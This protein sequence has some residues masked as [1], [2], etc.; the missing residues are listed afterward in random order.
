[1]FEKNDHRSVATWFVIVNKVTELVD[2]NATSLELSTKY[3][4]TECTKALAIVA[5]TLV[6]YIPAMHA[7]F[8]WDDDTHL[9]NNIVLQKDGLYRIWFTTE[10]VNYWPITWTSYWIEHQLWGLDPTGYHVDNVI[11]HA[12]AALLIWRILLRIRYVGAMH[13]LSVMVRIVSRIHRPCV[14]TTDSLVHTK[15]VT[16]FGHCRQTNM[17]YTKGQAFQSMREPSPRR[18]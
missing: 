6:I 7:G 9:L 18:L 8:V 5:T 17:V 16:S 12:F 11:L 1:M 14:A 10:F 2:T 3:V 4:A 15:E 13:C